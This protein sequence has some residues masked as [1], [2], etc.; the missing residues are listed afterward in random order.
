MKVLFDQAV[1]VDHV[2]SNLELCLDSE[3]AQAVR[4]RMKEKNFEVLGLERSGEVHGYV[5]EIDLEGGSCS[6]H[7][8]TFHPS[9]LLASGTSLKEALG[10]LRNKP[11]VFL[12]T[13]RE[14]SQIV[15]Q[16]DLQKAPVRLYLFGIV[17]L[18]EMHLTRLIPHIYPGD[19]WLEHVS[20]RRLEQARG[21]LA[22]RAKLGQDLNLIEC[23]QFSDKWQV[24]ISSPQFVGMSSSNSKTGFTKLFRESE[25]LR[26]RLAHANDAV[27]GSSWKKTIDLVAS[28]EIL[29]E[30]L[31]EISG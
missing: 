19:A 29:I 24:L 9:D 21:L 27:L 20:A 4:E 25:K 1:T 11:R 15:T 16:A 8:L 22:E 3:D 17:T 14:V 30:R 12:L 2:S 23:L 5:R 13:G 6:D 31:E 7:E 28:L 26:D 18:L 10:V